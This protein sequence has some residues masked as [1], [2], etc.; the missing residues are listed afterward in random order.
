MQTTEDEN[1][2]LVTSAT[3]QGQLEQTVAKCSRVFVPIRISN[4]LN[5]IALECKADQTA[6]IVRYLQFIAQYLG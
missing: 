4:E 3:K 2:H 1:H 5:K 6:E